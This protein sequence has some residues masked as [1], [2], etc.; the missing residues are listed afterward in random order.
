M[1]GIAGV[2]HSDGAPVDPSLL[3]RMTGLLTHRGP[4]A[5]GVYTTSPGAPLQVGLGHRRLSIIDLSQAGLQPMANEDKTVR[6]VFNGEIYN[7][8]DLRRELKSAGH[9]FKSNADTEVLVHGWE[10]WGEA[11][12]DRI[13]GMFAFAVLDETK[14]SLFLARDRF[15]KKPLY[16]M[17]TPSGIAFASELRSLLVHPECSRSLDRETISRFLLYEYA[18]APHTLVEGVKKLR[19]GHCM[20]WKR[21]HAQER[22]YWSV[23]FD[24]ESG[25]SIA[26]A[27]AETADRL[28]AAVQKRL[29]S[30]APLGVLL[31]GGLDSTAALALMAK[32]VD[33]R[34][35]RTF[36]IGFE[37]VSFDESRWAKRAAD[38]FGSHHA[39]LTLS[40]RDLIPAL[41]DVWNFLDDPIADGS[42]VPTY[43]LCRF[44]REHVKV[45][46]GGDG[47]DELFAGYDPFLAQP[48]GRVWEKVPSFIRGLAARA[49]ARLPV[50]TSNLSLDFK[51]RQFIK[52]VEYPEPGRHQVWL[53]SFAPHEQLGLFSEEMRSALEGFDPLAEVVE[54]LN[55]V[56]TRGAVDEMIAFYCNF[57][58]ADDILTKVDRS[59]MA[60]SLEVRSPFLDQ[61]LAE[62]VNGLP[63]SFK[64]RGTTRKFILKKALRGIVPDDILDRKKKGFGMPVADL[65]KNELKPL[66]REVFSESRVRDQGFFSPKAVSQL[67]DDHLSGRRD[68]RKQLF[69]L[70][71]FDQWHERFIKA[72]L[73]SIAAGP[74]VAP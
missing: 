41:E 22:S 4:D 10:E 73:N 15:G 61:D 38:H 13:T 30:D 66:A 54:R 9:V 43:L 3:E 6:V 25:A 49:A 17:E 62:Y 72:P 55:G 67:L 29:V 69:T 57:Y 26:Q 27:A 48:V 20:L 51:I 44:A 74:G 65:L 12:L 36:S 37:D 14:G 24:G 23:R 58:L 63:S 5:S 46:L 47:G 40:R 50:N 70:L 68:N 31:S 35:I 16:Y 53:G 32:E 59:S 1:C 71:M 8:K 19:P 11:L 56:H 7:F 33:P 42:I 45:V 18:P 64:L 28:S 60:A 39:S 34:S 2:A 21:R 52:G